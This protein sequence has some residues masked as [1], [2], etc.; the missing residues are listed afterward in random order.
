MQTRQGRGCVALHSVGIV[1]CLHWLNNQLSSIPYFCGRKSI[2]KV[3]RYMLLLL[4]LMLM[5]M[6]L[7]LLL[8][9]YCNP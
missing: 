4:L 2:I 8:L 3:D 9:P 1:L 7:L 5:L 6:L